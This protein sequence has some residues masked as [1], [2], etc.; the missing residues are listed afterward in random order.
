MKYRLLFLLALACMVIS[1]ANAI[2]DTEQQ[3]LLETGLPLVVVETIDGEEPTYE[4]SVAPPGCLGQ[5]IKNATKVPGRLRIITAGDTIYD[6]GDYE[7]GVSGMTIK[8]RGNWSAATPNK[9]FKIKLQ[10]KDDLLC[11]GDKR[12]K[13]KDWLLLRVP[14][15]NTMIGFKV[16]ELL[17]MQWTP[18]YQFVNVVMNEDYRGVYMLA[19][20]VKRNADCRIDVDK[21][22][23]YIF[24]L[25][26]YWWNEDVYVA[27]SF[28]DRGLNYTFK[29][30]DSDDITEAQ[31]SYFEEHI[32]EM[33]A[34]LNNNT[35]T[36]YID[37]PSFA[38][39]MLA[40]DILG[41]IDAAGSN[42]YLTKYDS[43]STSKIK[44]GPLW[45]F[46]HIMKADQWDKVHTMYYFQD[47]FKS[48][49]KT[50]SLTYADRWNEIKDSVFS[51][52]SDFFSQ[53]PQSAEGKALN[54][55]IPF[56]NDR[57]KTPINPV[58][59][60]CDEAEA[61]FSVRKQWL[62]SAIVS[63]TPVIPDSFSVSVTAGEG[64]S[65]VLSSEKVERGDSV[66]L[67]I[68]PDEDY[69]LASLTV[70]SLD[71]TGEVIDGQYTIPDVQADVEVTATF[72]TTVDVIT[73]GEDGLVAYCSDRDLDF[74]DI[75]GVRA[76]VATGFIRKSGE[77]VMMPVS[78][79]PAHEGL[80]IKGEPGTYKVHGA[81]P[82][83]YYMNMLKG[84][85]EA[86]S[87]E[88]TDGL[89][90]NY[91]L[92]D[93]WGGQAFYRV[94]EA[95]TMVPG[96]AILQLPTALDTEEGKLS[97]LFLSDAGDAGKE[98]VPARGDVNSDGAVNVADIASIIDIMAGSGGTENVPEGLEAVDL[99]LPSGTKWANINLG[100][101][102]PEDYGLYFAWGET[103][104]YTADTS[105]GRSFDWGSYKWREG[106][107]ISKYQ[108][109]E[110][111]YSD[112]DHK[113]I[114]EPEDDA[115]QANWG[116]Q[117]FIPSKEEVRELY[118]NTTTEWTTMNGVSGQQFTSK[119]NGRSIFLPAAGYRIYTSLER[120]G[121]QG[122]YWESQTLI[123]LSGCAY[124]IVIQPEGSSYD[125]S[126]AFSY[127]HRYYGRTIRPVHRK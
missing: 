61:Y 91:I 15:L 21:N 38:N 74:S 7:S 60:Y 52:L 97:L 80:V 82:S 64:G 116:G 112:N 26:A 4:I 23:G 113:S 30:P 12:Y 68:V 107:A 76:Y 55:S 16:N 89:L 33:E 94:E 1:K 127:Y 124:S 77:I 119:V 8:V 50:F 73:I 10:K 102:Q 53:F 19:E 58:E 99:G 108:A 24:E 22:T 75:K 111:G 34:S 121:T 63:I 47:L 93:G 59:T 69:V 56:H 40:H 70:D 104:G 123:G 120:E 11:R 126:G 48:K 95:G 114:L 122:T 28:S 14:N 51:C 27:S 96:S 32:L 117:W 57:W 20:S 81:Q 29:Y 3:Q 106:N 92:Q 86:L 118:E 25:D 5:S 62:D 79:I 105:D 37:V 83:A 125:P 49:D 115:A 90:T 43:S 66:I 17:G 109:Y 6:S 98:P 100:A 65:I 46:D 84:S 31:L 110:K 71:V 36:D 87:V 18:S 78:D 88:P 72:R 54:S 42:I 35:Y 44:T 13:D 101:Q 2:T 103:T 9:P 67:T 39:W 41:N 45:D 85:V